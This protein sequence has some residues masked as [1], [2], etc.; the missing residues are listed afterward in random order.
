MSVVTE[1]S[2]FDEELGRGKH[3]LVLQ[4]LESVSLRIE[5]AGKPAADTVTPAEVLCFRL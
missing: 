3:F 5:S 4:T 2:V 1:I